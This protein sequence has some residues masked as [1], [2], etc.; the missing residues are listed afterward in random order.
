VLVPFRPGDSRRRLGFSTLIF[1]LFLLLP[2]PVARA[3]G[4]QA[5]VQQVTA[6]DEQAV[7]AYAEGD[8][9]KMKKLLLKALSLGK[10][11]LGTQPV[12]ARVYLHLGVL[13]VDGLENRA[14]GVKYFVKALKTRPDLT[15]RSNM[16]TK[17]VMS[18]FAEADQQGA[19][20]NESPRAPAAAA[21]RKEPAEDNED[22]PVHPAEPERR[23]AKAASAPERCRADAEIADVKRQ[24][25]DELDRLEKA[26]SM[27]KDALKKESAESEKFR[28]DK[29][30]LERALGESRQRVTQLE[31]EIKQRDKRAAA[32]SQR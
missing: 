3:A 27:S 17:T 28:K 26:L 14:V 32:S 16:A 30:D 24:A 15:V 4:D 23:P 9:D 12:M 6:L 8:F 18:A 10:D 21:A 7:A 25:R 29:M 2:G 31:T 1:G 5:L 22:R 20:G 11:P 19:S 13:F